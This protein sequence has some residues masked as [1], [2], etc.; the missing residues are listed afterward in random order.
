VPGAPLAYAEPPAPISG[1]Y[2]TRIFALRLSGAPEA[3]SGP[4]ILR[5]MSPT[6]DPT[7]ALKERATQNALAGAGYPVPRVLA[8]SADRGPLGAG[9]LVMER[10]AGRPLLEVR[11]WGVSAALADAHLRLHALDA[12]SLLRALDEE[13]RAAGGAFDRRAVALESHLAALDRRIQRSPLPGLA[14]GM[15]WLLDHRPAPGRGVICHGDF[16]PQN[17]L[18]ARRGVTAVLDWPNVLVAE[19]ECDVA[20]TLV[21]LRLIPIELLPGPP[22]LRPVVAGL[23]SIMGTRYLARYR[24]ARPLD[25]ARLSYYEA[26]G[27]MRGLVRAAEGRVTGADNALD[28]SSFGDRLAARFSR[29]TGVAVSLPPVRG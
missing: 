3:W 24:R 19:P 27:C 23:R 12:E 13:G 29:V 21:I 4:L 18:A 20:A 15:R 6:Q 8:A 25:G 16:H 7:R 28:A 26:A 10:A 17:L 22:V 5:V 1:G 14:P 9:F 2:D 11:P